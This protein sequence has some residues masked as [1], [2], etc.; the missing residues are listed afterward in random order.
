MKSRTIF[1]RTAILLTTLL[2][3]FSRLQAQEW[4]KIINAGQYAEALGIAE[5]S[6]NN[7]FVAGYNVNKTTLDINT[8]LLKLDATGKLLKTI[9]L[10]DSLSAG[11]AF[12]ITP[13]K[14]NGVLIATI[15]EKVIKL[16]KNA[17]KLWEYKAKAD[18]VTEFANG[19]IFMLALEKD[20]LNKKTFLKNTLLSESGVKIWAKTTELPLLANFNHFTLQKDTIFCFATAKN[21]QNQKQFLTYT[22]DLLGNLLGSKAQNIDVDLPF[23]KRMDDGNLLLHSLGGVKEDLILRKMNGDKVLWEKKLSN[24]SD[25][26]PLTVYDI[27]EDKNHNII[28]AG[29]ETDIKA[30][31]AQTNA[32]IMIVDELGNMK[33]FERFA[34]EFKNDAAAVI[35][36]KDGSYAICGAYE[37]RNGIKFTDF[38]A[39]I[40]VIKTKAAAF[41]NVITGKIILDN[42]GNCKAD[43]AEQVLKNWTAY[44]DNTKGE[45]YFSVAQ[46]DGSFRILANGDALT[47]AAQIPSPTYK[48]TCLPTT[49]QFN[50]TTKTLNRDIFIQK[51]STCAY[52]TVDM[53]AQELR[54]CSTSSMLV[55]YSNKGAA[56]AQDAYATLRLDPN[57]TYVK[58][59]VQGEIQ[60]DGSIRFS[61]GNVGENANG[62]FSVEVKTECDNIL[63]NKT[64]CNKINVFSETVCAASSTVSR[65]KVDGNCK[66][67]KIQ[68]SI[69]NVG[70]K[71]MKTGKNYIVIE[72]DIM[73]MN[74]HFNLDSNQV[75]PIS[76]EA[77]PGKT[78]RLI[79]EQ[80]DSTLGT[81]ATVAFEECNK[82]GTTSTGFINQ[83][84]QGDDA[85]G[86]DMDCSMVNAIAIANNKKAVPE[87]FGN[88]HFINQNADLEYTIHF[89]NAGFDTA[90][91]LIIKDTLPAELDPRSIVAGT[92]S[93]R[94]TFDLMDRGV[95]RF[96]FEDIFLPS[97]SSDEKESGGFVKFSIKQRRDLPI[98]TLIN[99][100]AALY[101]DL[102][103]PILTNTVFHTIAENWLNF[104]PAKESILA[105]AD[106]KVY[107]NPFH[108]STTIEIL[109]EQKAAELRLFDAVGRVLRVEK[110]NENRLILERNNL[111][112]GFYMYQIQDETGR[113]LSNGKLIVQ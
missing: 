47:L 87:G 32:F 106:I 105:K 79:A 90:T 51:A 85:V 63:I 74:G 109:G 49:V 24:G 57:L 101:F 19:D 38:N 25:K 42:N 33:S 96:V 69:K 81:I 46:N 111:L 66:G 30:A 58:S 113:I 61:L 107:P 37:L 53:I 77:R 54:P 11:A 44:A 102:N 95:A 31:I 64:L 40:R 10:T 17:S 26:N 36:S 28:L 2:L 97:S 16:D 73:Y 7:Y 12:F 45:R 83:F 99:N 104:V 48:Q 59:S 70:G 98:K 23:V 5:T 9:E 18:F 8:L 75:L 55:S 13:T 67:D 68:F 108:E 80:T 6:D 65:I 62:Q 4:Q 82:T 41:S 56:E 110:F 94:Y 34:G 78:Y 1:L 27:K 29:T 21:S 100:H 88:Q 112:N 15:A 86:E 60:G 76:I 43:S 89:Q 14:N 35:Q 52:L 3:S 84:S 92:S 20:F 91:T 50:A 103:N 22:F 39:Q 93:H 72:D 71:A